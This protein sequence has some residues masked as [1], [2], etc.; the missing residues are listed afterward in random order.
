MRTPKLQVALK[1]TV[2]QK[3][4]NFKNFDYW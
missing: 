3:I 1:L 4:W 2:R